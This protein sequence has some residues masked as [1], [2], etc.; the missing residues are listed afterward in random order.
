MS[1]WVQ[2][3]VLM[4]GLLLMLGPGMA[5]A[6]DIPADVQS[7]FEHYVALPDQLLPVLQSAQDAASA[8]KAAEPLQA[9]LPKVY[10]ARRELKA[11]PSL[12]PEVAAELRRRYEQRMRADWGKVYDEIFRLRAAACYQCVPFFKQFQTLCL[13][14]EK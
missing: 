11:I 9:L 13:L 6:V 8:E 14:L 2:V 5:A 1:K 7:A 4:A 10:D 12:S 3:K